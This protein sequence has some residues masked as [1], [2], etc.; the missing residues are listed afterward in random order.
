MILKEFLELKESLQINVDKVSHF[1]KSVATCLEDLYLVGSTELIDKA[2]SPIPKNGKQTTVLAL[3]IF[4]G[5]TIV[6]NQDELTRKWNNEKPFSD[7]GS[8]FQAVC[9]EKKLYVIGGRKKRCWQPVKSVHVFSISNNK[10]TQGPS[11]N[12]DR[13]DMTSCFHDSSRSIFVIGGNCFNRNYLETIERLVLND[14]GEAVGEWEMITPMPVEATGSAA[15][16]LG[17]CLYVCGGTNKSGRMDLVQI[18]NVPTGTWKLGSPMKNRR[19]GHSATTVGNKV[20]VMGGSLTKFMS[21][22]SGSCEVYDPALNVWSSISS[23]PIPKYCFGAAVLND[24]IYIVGGYG[25]STKA[26]RFVHVYDTQTNKWSTGA[27]R[28][29][30]D[31]F[32]VCVSW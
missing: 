5:E 4:G 1:G 12:M 7:F 3:G 27:Q 6:G 20:Y 21:S 19:Y 16:A 25:D 23:M 18:F 8:G 11:L 32:T 9:Y 2:N 10:L 29:S 31:G 26:H 15:A 13:S 14:E 30:V 24:Q 22:L 28:K 17:D